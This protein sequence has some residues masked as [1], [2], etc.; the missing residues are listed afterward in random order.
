MRKIIAALS[1][2]ALSATSVLAQDANLSPPP[3]LTEAGARTVMAKVVDGFIRPGYRRFSESSGQLTTA[4]MQLCAAPSPETLGQA[5]QAFATAAT[6]W[7]RIEVVRVGPVIEKNRFE[8]ILFYPDRKGTGLRQVQALLANPDETAT[9]PDGLA[10]KSVAMQGLGA[11]EF[12]LHGTDAQ[13]LSGEANGFRCRYGLAVAGNVQRVA[14]DLVE[15][16]DDPD[17]IA[18]DWKAPG[19][20]SAVFRTPREAMTEVLGILV[21]AAEALRD[22]RVETFYKGE[23]NNTFPRQ[24]LFW[25]SGLTFPMLNG[26]LRG[27]KDL[28]DTSG[29]KDL[30][31]PDQR[32]IISSIDFVLASLTRVTKTLTPDVDAAVTDEAQRQKLDFVLLNSRDLILR[33]NDSL[34]G[35][36]GLGAGF[37]FSDGD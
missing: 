7:A 32:S 6:D 31:S 37:S 17:G 23:S 9:T 34:G 13:T 29:L 20:D 5:R 14:T 3:E 10:G 21:H 12:V 11:L 15:V 36:L 26:N 30:L 24:A 19:P 18:R 27:I 25:R 28:L 22:Q 8:R 2:I 35:G 16:W 4:M 33:L 1:L